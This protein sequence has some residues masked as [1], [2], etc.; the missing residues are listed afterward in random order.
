MAIWSKE[1]DERVDAWLWRVIVS[2]W[3]PL[4]VAGFW[5][6][7]YMCGVYIGDLLF[8]LSQQS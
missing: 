5:L 7:G 8:W 1:T 3:S 2:R 4:W 6:S